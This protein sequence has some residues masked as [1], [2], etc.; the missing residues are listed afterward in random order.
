MTKPQLPTKLFAA[1]EWTD[2]GG[3]LEELRV[4]TGEA[5]E[6]YCRESAANWRQHALDT[7]DTDPVTESDLL[8]LH[9]WL[10]EHWLFEQGPATDD[11]ER[12]D[13]YDV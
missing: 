2:A 10:F 1:Y 11:Y 13:E 6:T 3:E 9:H 4:L 8:T 12:G 5:L 7:G